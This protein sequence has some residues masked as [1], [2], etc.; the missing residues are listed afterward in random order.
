MPPD[1]NCKWVLLA[2]DSNTR[3]ILPHLDALAERFAMNVTVWP[4]ASRS[5][6]PLREG[7]PAKSHERCDMRWFDQERTYVGGGGGGRSCLLLSFRF[8]RWPSKITSILPLR[9][10]RVC[11]DGVYRTPR[12]HEC[13][14]NDRVAL[15]AL[16]AMLAPSSDPRRQ[17]TTR[18]CDE[19]QHFD[20]PGCGLDPLALAPPPLR[21]GSLRQPT[22]P[23]LVYLAH[24]TWH[25]VDE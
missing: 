13:K 20:A 11:A 9:T 24:P 19:Y 17:R 14:E 8:V 6:D 7:Q 25:A 5:R 1:T 10:P 3:N 12:F 22:H 18:C 23:S 21:A 4:P 2:G 16:D 15:G